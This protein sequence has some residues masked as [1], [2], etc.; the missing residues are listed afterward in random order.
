MTNTERDLSWSLDTLTATAHDIDS[1]KRAAEARLI[2]LV[3]QARR[4]GATWQQIADSLG[5]SRQAAHE[6]FNL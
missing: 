2:G 4:D 1:E 5:T 3:H 6:R